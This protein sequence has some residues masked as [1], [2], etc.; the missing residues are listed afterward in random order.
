M[1]SNILSALFPAVEAAILNS[2]GLKRPG[3]YPIPNSKF[4]FIEAQTYFKELA[5]KLGV[6]FLATEF[7]VASTKDGT[8][9]VTPCLKA[10]F[11]KGQLTP[12]I[13]WGNGQFPVTLEQLYSAGYRLQVAEKCV[14]L[15]NEG[16]SYSDETKFTMLP[17]AWGWNETEKSS[18]R[19][20]SLT[21][22]SLNFLLKNGGLTP[23]LAVVKQPRKK[24]V[25]LPETTKVLTV[26]GVEFVP[27]YK[28]IGEEA[29][30][31]FAE[32]SG[33]YA[34]VG[35]A[36]KRLVSMGR[37]HGITPKTP[38][39]L[40]IGGRSAATFKDETGQTKNYTRIETTL[41]LHD[42]VD[43]GELLCLD[44]GFE[45]LSY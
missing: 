29:L 11:V 17:V 40:T 19:P 13:S 14:Y 23:L 18:L 34:L 16:H 41:Q 22:H 6:D 38:G 28:G 33:N 44:G 43:L 1:S 42:D 31:K 2:P 12:V 5:M 37:N 7:T 30:V 20:A 15:T 32:V 10:S 39:I 26:V 35:S 27:G 8:M 21:P 45:D 4:P 9:V 3:F 25:D 36:K 24:L